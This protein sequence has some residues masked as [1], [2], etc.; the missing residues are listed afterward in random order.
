MSI[1]GKW[2]VLDSNSTSGFIS[3]D[4]DGYALIKEDD[5]P[6]IGGREFILEGRKGQISYSVNY[7][8]KPIEI[9]LIITELDSNRELR[10]LCIAEFIDQDTLLFTYSFDIAARPLDFDSH[11][12]LTLKRTKLD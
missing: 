11:E 2:S 4:K 3:F 9:D 12:V 7:D 5:G 10:M 6:V 8:K 1:I